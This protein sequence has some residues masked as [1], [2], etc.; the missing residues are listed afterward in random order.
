ML[1][2]KKM[3]CFPAGSAHGKEKGGL[4]AFG[5]DVVARMERKKIFVD[6]AHASQRSILELVAIATRPILSS[7]TGKFILFYNLFK[8][9]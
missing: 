6:V 5:R 1:T 3:C 2:T 4:T 9:F 7:H 8:Y